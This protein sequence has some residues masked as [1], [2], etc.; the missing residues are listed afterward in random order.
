MKRLLVKLFSCGNQSTNGII[1]IMPYFA[2]WKSVNEFD[3]NMGGDEPCSTSDQYRSWLVI[4]NRHPIQSL[5]YCVVKI[6]Y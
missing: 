4:T 3:G 6:P 1:I 2:F 5:V